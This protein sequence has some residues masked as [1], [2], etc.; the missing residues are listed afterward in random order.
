MYRPPVG[1]S[2]G[3]S[4]NHLN[5]TGP[6]WDAFMVDLDQ[7]F[8]KFGVPQGERDELVAIVNSTRGDIVA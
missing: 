5:I 4:H 6:E 2:M 7:T 3:D 1:M 8:E